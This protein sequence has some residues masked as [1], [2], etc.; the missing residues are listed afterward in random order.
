MAKITAS[1]MRAH[2]LQLSTDHDIRIEWRRDTD[3]A[4]AARAVNLISI[5]QIRSAI[6]YAIAL[7]EIGHLLGPG[8][9]ASRMRCERG[10]WR[11]AKTNAIAW[12]AS[13]NKTERRSLA[14]CECNARRAKAVGKKPAGKRRGDSA[15]CARTH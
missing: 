12:L 4:W 7:H 1:Q 15:Q 9:R 11:W 14:W 2:I 10:A 3:G 13:M 8:Q 5:P 6:S